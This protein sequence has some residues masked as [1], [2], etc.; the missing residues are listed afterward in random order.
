MMRCL[1]AAV[2]F[3]KCL[4]R[5]MR[6]L[7]KESKVISTSLKFGVLKVPNLI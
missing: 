6:D 2:L 7:V 1:A 3:G 5:K 4:N